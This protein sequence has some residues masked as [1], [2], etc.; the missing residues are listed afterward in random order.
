MKFL[1][2]F[3][4]FAAV[5]AVLAPFSACLAMPHRV[6]LA[7]FSH[8]EKAFASAIVMDV[9]TKEILFEYNA[10][11]SWVPA[12]LTK[13]VGAL[14]F[15][16]RQ[17]AWDAIVSLKEEDEVGGGRLR[18]DSGATMSIQDLMYSSIVGSANNAATAFARLSGLGWDN[19]VSAM[20]RKV[21]DLG[22]KNSYFEDAS[23]MDVDNRTTAREMLTIATAAFNQSYIQ[24]PASTSEYSFTIRNT[25]ELKTVKNTNDLLLDPDNGL[26]VTGGKTGFLYESLHNLVY[27]VRPAKD[28]TKRELLIVVLG[29]PSRADL[30]VQAEALAKW[31]WQTYSWDGLPSADL[32]E[33]AAIP[34]GTLIK[35]PDSPAVWYVWKGKKYVLLDGVFL[36]HYFP[37][38]PI[39]TVSPEIVEAFTS[40]RPYTF[41]DGELLKS[42]I[43]PVVYYV[44]RGMLRPISTEAAFLS[45]GWK[46][47]DIV[48]AP[49][50]L[51]NTYSQGLAINTQNTNSILLTSR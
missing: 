49:A 9:N 20:N 27:R 13:L 14:V 51:L 40:A 35:K 47:S 28:D 30:F 6:A 42:P 38:T 37:A 29:A 11:K 45:M 12:S 10:D 21:R 17:P 36:D 4:V 33:A 5:S 41:D 3:W 31:S 43:S 2:F 34:N 23:G 16:E 18:V 48:T 39:K 24:K 46:W 25:G 15:V 22:L 1:R 32:A 26:Y 44:E 19:F 8:T 7:D 50:W